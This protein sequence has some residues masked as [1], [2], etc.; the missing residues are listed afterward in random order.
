MM[1]SAGDLELTPRCLAE[2]GAVALLLHLPQYGAVDRRVRRLAV[3][4]PVAGLKGALDDGLAV[5]RLA[6]GHPVGRKSPVTR[7]I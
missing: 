5:E 1:L 2:A 7:M 3:R 4:A 6:L